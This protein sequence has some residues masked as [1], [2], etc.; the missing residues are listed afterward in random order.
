MIPRYLF[1]VEVR[2]FNFPCLCDE[3]FISDCCDVDF[4]SFE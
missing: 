2:L 1:V 3:G 4:S